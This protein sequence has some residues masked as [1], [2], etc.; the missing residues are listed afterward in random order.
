[1]GYEL[2]HG[3][4]L[5]VLRTMPSESV[6][7]CVTSPPYWNLRDYGMDGQIG[8][9]ST[10]AEY[11]ARLVEVFEEV[12]RVL[13]DDGV[14]WLNLGDAMKD[15]N[16]LGIPHRVVFALQDAMWI[17]RDEIVWSKPNPM[18]ESVTDRTTKAHEFMFLLAKQPAYYYDAVAVMEPVTR[19]TDCAAASSIFGAKSSQRGGKE[20]SRLGKEWLK[21]IRNRRSVWTVATKPYSGA[22]FAV[23][24][25]KLI[26]PCILA[27]S[28]AGDTVLDC[29]SGSGTTG[30]VALEH[31]RN[32][33]GIE[34]NPAYI[35]LA[36]ERIR[37]T[38]PQLQA[39]PA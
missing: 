11:V 6:Q 12:R 14:L 8:L 19:K 16:R 39:V 9:E 34:L 4:A 2:H 38:Q 33:I 17:W 37:N 1:M 27:G 35:E 29:F 15:K 26:T 36:H 30:A 18:P 3:D 5:T 31:G 13:R 21:N 20:S 28:R 32:Y 24:P 23:F 10:L 25:P 7:T 22:H